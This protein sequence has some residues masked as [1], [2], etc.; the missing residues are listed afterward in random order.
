MFFD[1]FTSES[2]LLSHEDEYETF[3]TAFAA[4]AADYISSSASTC[5]YIR[6]LNFLCRF[7][8]K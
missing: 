3:Y 5:E 1:F 4:L 8:L 7:S 6:D 2:E